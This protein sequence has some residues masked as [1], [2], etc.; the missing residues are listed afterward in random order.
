MKIVVYVGEKLKNSKVKFS[1]LFSLSFTLVDLV[2]LVPDI[3]S[4]IFGSHLIDLKAL[5]ALRALK[6]LRLS[7]VFSK[8]KLLFDYILNFFRYRLYGQGLVLGINLSVLVVFGAVFSFVHYEY[9]VYLGK[10]NI[11]LSNS[12]NWGLNIFISPYGESYT[13]APSNSLKVIAFIGSSFGLFVYASIIGVFSN[14]YDG[15]FDI[16]DKGVG[17]TT[18]K[19]DD[20]V[21]VGWNNLI[22]SLCEHV[23]KTLGRR[24]V[25]VAGMDKLKVRDAFENSSC[26]EVVFNHS[27]FEYVK[28]D[29][30]C[31]DELEKINIWHASKI[32]IVYD[33]EVK[34]GNESSFYSGNIK[35]AK[36]LFTMKTI[37]HMLKKHGADTRIVCEIFSKSNTGLFEDYPEVEIVS[38]ESLFSNVFSQVVLQDDILNVYKRLLK[39]EDK[40]LYVV[41][42]QDGNYQIADC[43]S[44]YY[45]YQENFSKQGVGVIGLYF[46]SFMGERS[47]V[48]LSPSETELKNAIDNYPKNRFKPNFILLAESPQVLDEFKLTNKLRCA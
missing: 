16:M 43:P 40:E 8:N 39:T 18:I 36:I 25:V 42:F 22:P 11:A 15:I 35:D 32:V 7:R 26:G 14:M 24:V 45:S 3:V 46:A 31:K 30:S 4:H 2:A 13:N 44:N 21:I 38:K 23:V 17:M 5:R 37:L 10:S 28:T 9:L 33:E 48:I 12:I 41:P 27:L 6:L 29:Y 47:G 19:K 34:E 1:G 20:F